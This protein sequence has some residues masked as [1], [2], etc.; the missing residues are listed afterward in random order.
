MHVGAHTGRVTQRA[1][2]SLGARWDHFTK[3]WGFEA[4][5]GVFTVGVVL[6]FVL[7]DFWWALVS[8]VL[9]ALVW[10]P[11]AVGVVRSF[12]QGYREGD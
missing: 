4:W 2:D 1:D 8:K 3:A 7:N 11:L 9:I 10:I 6:I 5:F 12:R